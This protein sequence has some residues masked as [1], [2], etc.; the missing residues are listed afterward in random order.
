MFRKSLITAVAA[1][2]VF[3]ASGALANDCS[4]TRDLN[5]T[6]VDAAGIEQVRIDAAAGSLEVIGVETD[7]I[8]AGGKACASSA[9]RLDGIELRSRHVGNVLEIEVKIES[10]GGFFFRR[11]YA[12][13]DLKVELPKG[14]SVEIDDGSGSIEVR[15]VGDLDID[16]GSGSIEVTNAGNTRIDDGSG[17][18]D[19]NGLR[20]D[21]EIE[22]GSGRIDVR[23][24][25]GTV[26]V[27][28]GSGS[29]E[30]TRVGGSVIIVDDGSGSIRVTEVKGDL[31]VGDH[32]SGG[33]SFDRIDGSVSVK[34]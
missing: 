8:R 4:H 17:S 3:S 26:R 7:S 18:I 28:D 9:S 2:F 6:P 23:D 15:D 19:I 27:D 14:M 32:G 16:D 29:V 11:T 30:I 22:D 34:D 21:L 13:L 20:G 10:A 1:T 25:A 33:L 24:V 12:Q 5:I 31:R